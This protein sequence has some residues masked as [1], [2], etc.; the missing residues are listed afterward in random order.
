MLN[1]IIQSSLLFIALYLINKRLGLKQTIAFFIAVLYLNPITMSL[2]LQFSTVYY[3]TLLSNIFI[4]LKDK[5]DLRSNGYKYFL[6][7]GIITV[8]F[9]FLTYPLIT[10]GITLLTYLSI[11]YKREVINIKDVI[12]CSIMWLVGYG[13]MWLS[14]WLLGSLITGNNLI[15]DAYNQAKFRVSRENYTILDVIDRNIFESFFDYKVGKTLIIIVVVSLIILIFLKIIKIKYINIKIIVP[16]LLISIYPFIW[17]AVL[18]NHSYIH[19]WMTYRN[20][21]ISIY[22][23]ILI[24]SNAFSI[25]YRSSNLRAKTS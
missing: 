23:L 9:D 4:L 6:F 13:G 3:I 21:A 19:F 5:E 11:I 12:I 2:S 24:I 10:L 15:L 8:Y 22:A 1:G 17:Y 7:I 25:N 20:L 16:Y 14:K 18:T